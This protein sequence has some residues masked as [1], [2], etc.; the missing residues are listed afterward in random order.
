MTTRQTTSEHLA[1]IIEDDYDAAILINEALKNAGFTTELIQDGQA[2][3]Q[4]LNTVEP[5]LIALDMHL[6]NISGDKL[7]RQI[8]KTEHLK[9]T[10]VMIITA[11]P[12]M[13]RSVEDAATLILLKP[14]TY[15]QM[16]QL[17]QR[18]HPGST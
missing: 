12:L 14:A 11:D 15:Q 2:A 7:L 9:T 17:A 5:S 16:N 4:R 6:P 18:L 8:R 3:S 1:L 10:K 13:A